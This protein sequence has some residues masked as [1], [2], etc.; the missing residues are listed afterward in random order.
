MIKVAYIISSYII[1]SLESNCLLQT[2]IY[3]QVAKFNINMNYFDKI[4]MSRHYATKFA[5]NPIFLY[6][7][8]PF[9]FKIH[10][11]TYSDQSE[12]CITQVYEN[13]YCAMLFQQTSLL[14]FYISPIEY[15][16]TKC[17]DLLMY[18]KIR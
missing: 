2:G 15:N 16:V 1:I 11:P 4:C 17:Y 6:R 5:E 8:V 9:M 7:F 18:N 3:K 14:I 12:Y 10:L 13:T